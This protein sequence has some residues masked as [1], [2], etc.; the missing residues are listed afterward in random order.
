MG[1]LTMQIGMRAMQNPDEVGAAAVDYLYF[2]GY[3]TLAYLWARM[4]LVAQKHWL[5][6]QQMLTST[7]LKSPL[8]V[9]TSRKSCHVFVHM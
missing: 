8:L 2:S 5:Q 3:V 9:S 1:R 7:M 4:A 6:V